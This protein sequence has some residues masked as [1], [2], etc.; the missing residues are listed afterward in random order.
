ME[1]AAKALGAEKDFKLFSSMITSKP[2][3]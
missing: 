2:F 1:V 3:A